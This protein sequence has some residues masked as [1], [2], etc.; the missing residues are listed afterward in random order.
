M[1]E[2]KD[3]AVVPRDGSK[4][5]PQLLRKKEKCAHT[6]R[7]TGGGRG[8]GEINYEMATL[9]TV[10]SVS[11]NTPQRQGLTHHVRY[12]SDLAAPPA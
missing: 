6:M 10:S 7:I 4:E 8:L 12:S 2:S 5:R 3:R 9:G 1:A 11:C